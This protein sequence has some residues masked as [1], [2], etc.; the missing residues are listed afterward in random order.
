MSNSITG[1]VGATISYSIDH[2]SGMMQY[3]VKTP[4]VLFRNTVPIHRVR[5]RKDDLTEAD[6]YAFV[7]K[8]HGSSPKGS[9]TDNSEST[10]TKSAALNTVLTV[11]TDASDSTDS[12]PT[13]PIT[14]DDPKKTRFKYRVAS[15][16]NG[17]ITASI[18]NHTFIVLTVDKDRESVG[19]ACTYNPHNKYDEAIDFFV[20]L[21]LNE[22]DGARVFSNSFSTKSN[23]TDSNPTESEPKPEGSGYKVLTI[24][25]DDKFDRKDLNNH[26]VSKDYLADVIKEMVDYLGKKFHARKLRDKS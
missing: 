1:T 21:K 10:I 8:K 26:F 2:F 3:T 14:R 20:P 15:D 17:R 6:I 7:C 11:P 4:F 19:V 12:S 5:G 9:S 16:G 25:D 22:R 24:A 13:V 18:G 23:S